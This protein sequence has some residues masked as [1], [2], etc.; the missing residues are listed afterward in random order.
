MPETYSVTKAVLRAPVRNW[1]LRRARNSGVTA[2]LRTTIASSTASATR[3]SFQLYQN[4]T[5]RNTNRNGQSSSSATAAPETNSRICST[6]F[7]RATSTPVWR[8]SK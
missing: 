1:W 3:V 6:A 8:A 2:T 5:A 4:I 7:R